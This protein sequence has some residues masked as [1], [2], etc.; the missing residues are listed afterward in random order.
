MFYLTSDLT[1]LKLIQNTDFRRRTIRALVHINISFFPN[2]RLIAGLLILKRL[3]YSADRFGI[4]FTDESREIKYPL[5]KCK[6]SSIGL[7]NA[8]ANLYNASLSSRIIRN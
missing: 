6:L 1:F 3:I 5:V 8:N 4:V 2:R 7:F